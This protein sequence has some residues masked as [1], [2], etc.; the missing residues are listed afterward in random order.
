VVRH[1]CDHCPLDTQNPS[2]YTPYTKKK[3]LSIQLNQEKFQDKTTLAI[4]NGVKKFLPVLAL[5]EEDNR[6]NPKIAKEASK[7]D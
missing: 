7:E 2:S 1:I 3:F 6:S 5:K 4:V